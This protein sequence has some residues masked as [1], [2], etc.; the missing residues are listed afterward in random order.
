MGS[1]LPARI[2][3]LD[4][5]RIGVISVLRNLPVTATEWEEHFQIG[6]IEYRV[7]G[8]A[9][10]GRPHGIDADVMLAVQTLFF[11]AGCPENG[12]VETT[13]YALLKLSGHGTSGDMYD[14]LKD[15][16]LRTEAVRW[17]HSRYEWTTD[18]SQ[19]KI[20]TSATGLF[21]QVDMREAVRI[22]AGT[23][24]L[25]PEATLRI[26]LTPAFAA[27]IRAGAYQLLDAEMLGSLEQP[28]ARSLYRVLQAHRVQID[29]SLTGELTVTL[30]DWLSA[31]GITGRIDSAKDTLAR[32]HERMVDKGYLVGVAWHGRGMK[33]RLTYQFTRTHADPELVALLIEQGVTRPVAEALSTDH[34][35]RIRPAVDAV[36]VRIS[37]GYVP[38]SRAAVVVDAVRHPDRYVDEPGV[39]PSPQP[40]GN[41]RGTK[42]SVAE[43]RAAAQQVPLLTLPEQPADRRETLISAFKIL[44]RRD[45]SNAERL[46]LDT[47]SEEGLTALTSA[48]MSRKK[49]LALSMLGSLSS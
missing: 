11:W 28:G 48:L 27:S 9:A 7:K 38:R 12:L 21:A 45:V 29:G 40:G 5:S 23:Q 3:E 43:R 1:E 30:S 8:R 13:P 6:S 20:D 22:S 24:A 25:D 47:L 10:L 31:C 36:K 37:S 18:R 46:A 4:L 32:A 19:A 39:S 2:S 41:N 15:S 44:F 17:T 14:R 16:L 26:Y 42:K 33:T 34:P 35:E 49:D